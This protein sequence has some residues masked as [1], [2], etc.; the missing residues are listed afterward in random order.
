MQKWLFGIEKKWQTVHLIAGYVIPTLKL[1]KRNRHNITLH[2]RHWQMIDF[3]TDNREVKCVVCSLC[4]MSESMR[5]VWL[6]FN[7]LISMTDWIYIL[8]Y[9]HIWWQTEAGR[10]RASCRVPTELDGNPQ[11]WE[12][13]MGSLWQFDNTAQWPVGGSGGRI[14]TYF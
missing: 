1:V 4:R 14:V 5:L 3:S 7:F 12:C 11:T 8:Y 10:L 2:S 9:I 13:E 6:R